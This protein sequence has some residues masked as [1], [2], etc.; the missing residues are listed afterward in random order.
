MRIWNSP[1]MFK[2]LGLAVRSSGE[3]LDQAYQC[4]DGNGKVTLVCLLEDHEMKKACN[5]ASLCEQ[6]LF[7]LT[8]SLC[9]LTCQSH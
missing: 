5:L 9:P 4:S 1:L 2:E 7:S 8:N 6:E 3:A